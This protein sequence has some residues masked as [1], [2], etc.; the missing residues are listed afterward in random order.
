MKRVF[1]RLVSVPSEQNMGERNN[2][3]YNYKKTPKNP[4]NKTGQLWIQTN[5][6][7]PVYSEL[8]E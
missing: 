8:E 6:T 1:R 4:H 3:N 7:H 2:N 5:I